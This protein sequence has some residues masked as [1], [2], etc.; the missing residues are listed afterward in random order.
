MNCS[1]QDGCYGN[2][3]REYYCESNSLGCDYNTLNCTIRN[4]ATGYCS[5]SCGDYIDHNGENLISCTDDLDNDCDLL[6]DDND[7]DCVQCGNNI[8]E[9][10]EQCDDGALNNNNNRC[11]TNCVWNT[12]GDSFICSGSNCN[13]AG[14]PAI[15]EECDIFNLN[16]QTCQTQGFMGGNLLCYP[17]SHP[18]QCTFNTAN[19]YNCGVEGTSCSIVN[20][21]SNCCNNAQQ[22]PGFMCRYYEFESPTI[23]YNKNCCANGLE[24]HKNCVWDIYNP[25]QGN[26][27]E[28]QTCTP[29]GSSS[30][31][32]ACCD[33]PNDCVNNNVCYSDGTT[34]NIYTSPTNTALEQC[35]NAHWCPDSYEWNDL[36]QYCE[37][38][39]E[40]CNGPLPNYCPY[41]IL[42]QT[43]TYFNT[44]IC[45]G[46][47]P[48]YFESCCYDFTLGIITI[49]NYM[50]V[51]VYG[52]PSGSGFGSGT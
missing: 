44:P 23:P 9:G 16:G 29:E 25:S 51:Q 4:T 36:E 39:A 49:Y 38:V 50:N 11:K 40:P 5:C 14:D 35:S 26:I 15:H 3:E 22:P 43:T 17:P 30:T 18:L 33:N 2:I 32:I 46:S 42:T 10:S 12:C 28:Y 24:T 41:D 6:I 47:P 48:N 7:P 27:F 1:F 19:C 21:L 34:V 45:F 52:N 37:P 13:N 20:Q 31:D 8:V